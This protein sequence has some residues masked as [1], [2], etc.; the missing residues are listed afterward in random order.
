M[1]EPTER[2]RRV[3]YAGG[4]IIF[5]LMRF[6]AKELD[7][8]AADPRLASLYRRHFELLARL[9][10]ELESDAAL[11]PLAPRPME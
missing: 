11:G 2:E 6:T 9:R 5:G 1:P 4:A 10:R 3:F 7:E 8:A